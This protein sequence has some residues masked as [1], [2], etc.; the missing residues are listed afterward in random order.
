MFHMQEGLQDE[1]LTLQQQ[2]TWLQSHASLQD[3]INKDLMQEV[4]HLREALAS[5]SAVPIAES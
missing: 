2:L 5:L 1:V 4:L 3:N